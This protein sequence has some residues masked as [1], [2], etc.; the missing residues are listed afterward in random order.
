MRYSL[1]FWRFRNLSFYSSLPPYPA[2]LKSNKEINIYIQTLPPS[3]TFSSSSAVDEE[4][5]T[6]LVAYLHSYPIIQITEKEWYDSKMR[7]QLIPQDSKATAQ[8]WSN[9]TLQMVLVVA[10][11]AC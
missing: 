5:T 4:A 8:G 11:D 2:H 1:W 3:P 9:D 6:D 7:C 10:T